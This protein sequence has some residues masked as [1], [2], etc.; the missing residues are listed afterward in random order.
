MIEFKNIE[1]CLVCHKSDSSEKFKFLSKDTNWYSAMKCNNCGLVYGNP[2]PILTSASINEIYASEYY[3]NY[4]GADVS[5]QDKEVASYYMECYKKEFAIY[6]KY[7]TK[8]DSL[9]VLDVGCG[10]GKFLE[11]FRS[12]G[13]DCLGLE[14]SETSRKIA[15]SKGFQVIDLPFL[16]MPAS[17]GLYDFIFLDNVIEHINEPNAFAEKAFGLLNSGGVFVTKTPNSDSLNEVL[18]TVMLRVLPVFMSNGLMKFIKKTTGKGSGT[19]HRYGN[20]H[21]PVHLAIYNK[22]SITTLLTQAGFKKEQVHVFR[23]SPNHPDWSVPEKGSGLF[24]QLKKLFDKLSNSLD[25][26]EFLITVAKKD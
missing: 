17:N 8:K 13:W 7:T 21:P 6:S 25:K 3:D 18:Q 10:D 16:E 2:Q 15:I 1:N 19:V 24:F 20:L 9:K 5:Y 26:G 11:I 14:P 22:S 23:I 12:N 4:F